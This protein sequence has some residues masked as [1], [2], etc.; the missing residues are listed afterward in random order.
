[1]TVITTARG[2]V[3]YDTF[4]D[5]GAPPL[6]L[7]QG[8]S[9]QRLGWRPG[10]CQALAE[11]GF[12]VIRHDNRDVGESQHF[13]P[14]ET[15]DGGYGIAD[16]ADDTVALLDELALD[17]VHV[18]GQSMGGMVAQLLAT[19]HPS[20]V[21]SLGLLY[22]A[23]SIRHIIDAGDAVE[24]LQAPPPTTREEFIAAYLLNEANC[25]SPGYPQDTDWIAELGGRM[26]A[27]GVDPTGVIRQ[28]Q[29]LLSLPDQVE[30]DRS[31]AVPTAIIPGDGHRLIDFHASE[32]LHAVIPGST[33]TII[34]GMGHELPPT[35]WPR[36]TA[37]LAENA[38]LARAD[39]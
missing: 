36:L 20:R 1:M 26:W 3:G 4:G 29:A 12:H 27:V 14:T 8:F 37:V 9:A 33:L 23:A 21:R 35:L 7:I 13:R 39:V 2:A 15:D 38:S 31:I 34:P 30:A 16:L 10:F 18:V 22:T 19:G 32:E 25:A 17:A 11:L 28:A 5:V 6:V 24:R